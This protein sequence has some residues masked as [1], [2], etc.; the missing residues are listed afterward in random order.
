MT[1]RLR[2]STAVTISFGRFVDSTDAVTAET[3]L[4]ITPSLRLLSK[5]GA[6]QAAT[7]DGSNATH[8]AGGI[9]RCTLTATDTNTVGTLKLY[10]T[11]SGALPYQEDFEVLPAAV[12]DAERIDP[13]MG[14]ALHYGTAQSGAS[15]AV[16]LA[17]TASSTDGWYTG[18]KVVILSGTGARQSRYV[19]GYTGSSRSCAIDRAWVTNPDATSVVAVLPVGFLVSTLDAVADAVHDEQVDGST[20]FRQSTR[21]Q[22]AVLAGKAS[23][24][25][26]TTATYRDLA[27]TKNRVVATVDTSGNRTAVT[28]D[29]T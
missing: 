25:A 6:V 23:G 16:A 28:R 1:T 29:V 18:Q 17:T 27:D 20:T 22:N 10:V 12:F 7:S 26:T 15:L 8:D 5:A 14:Q 13:L 11:A 2:Q 19:T 3:A 4:T 24:L 9:Y 21:L